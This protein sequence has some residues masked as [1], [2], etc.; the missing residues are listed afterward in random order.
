[1]IQVYRTRIELL[2]RVLNK[3]EKQKSGNPTK[4]EEDVI[5]I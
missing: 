2:E 4:H 1:M 5:K 3:V